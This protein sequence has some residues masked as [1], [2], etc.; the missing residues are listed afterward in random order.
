VAAE[1]QVLVI[2]DRMSNMKGQEVDGIHFLTRPDLPAAIFTL[3]HSKP[4]LV[5][6]S[7]FSEDPEKLQ[8]LREQAKRQGLP[9]VS[10]GE[11]NPAGGLIDLSNPD[12]EDLVSGRLNSLLRELLSSRAM[13]EDWDDLRG[14]NIEGIE[15]SLSLLHGLPVGIWLLNLEGELFYANKSLEGIDPLN[16]PELLNHARYLINQGITKAEFTDNNGSWSIGIEEGHEWESQ[17]CFRVL[18]T[19]N[20]EQ[21][22]EVLPLWPERFGWEWIL[23]VKG[24]IQK[25]SDGLKAFRGVSAEIIG[26]DIEEALPFLEGSIL[27]KPILGIQQFRAQADNPDSPLYELSELPPESYGMNG[28][29]FILRKAS[30]SKPD[31]SSISF[32][33]LVHIASH[34]LREPVRV[35]MN[36][37]QLV[38]RKFEREDD[39]EGKEFIEY[40]LASGKRMDAYLKQLKQLIQLGQN[41]LWKPCPVRK[42]VRDMEEKIRNENNRGFTLIVPDEM[43]EINAENRELELLVYNLISNAVKFSE[44]DP[45]VRIS[46]RDLGNQWLF[47]FSDNGRGIPEGFAESIFDVSRRLELS[48]SPEGAGL[49]LSICKAIVESANGKI[50][51]DSKENMG[52]TVSFT[53][54]QKQ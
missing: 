52:T 1:Y 41:R 49:G 33:D 13:K 35:I 29:L 34:D 7:R 8:L 5:V 40:I 30:D 32:N 16:H 39:Q 50:W 38:S 45:E 14:R 24:K 43:P 12:P 48:A 27:G 51:V 46:V 42:V 25:H 54:P 47:S 44:R 4:D 18:V 28:R 15:Q 26:K 20:Q 2:D 22:A 6:L 36:Y 37:G 3:N 31:D 53:W 10:L 9:V 17:A 19:K 23:A 11:P 21:K